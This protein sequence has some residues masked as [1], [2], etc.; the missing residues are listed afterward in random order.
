MARAR[1]LTSEALISRVGLYDHPNCITRRDAFFKKIRNVLELQFANGKSYK[2]GGIV[3]YDHKND[4]LQFEVRDSY[5]AELKDAIN[6]YAKGDN[7]KAAQLQ[8]FAVQKIESAQ[9]VRT[10][11]GS[12]NL[13]HLKRVISV[14]LLEDLQGEERRVAVDM[15]C[16]ALADSFLSFGG[17]WGASEAGVWVKEEGDDFIATFQINHNDLPPSLIDLE[18]SKHEGVFPSVLISAKED[19][20]T[21]GISIYL[22]QDGESVLVYQGAIT[23]E[24]RPEL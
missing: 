2:L 23:L 15:L 16:E 4:K 11:E 17:Q 1:F 20:L 7:S 9:T 19:Y 5:S 10:L 24:D 6:M 12:K 8:E 18:N 14:S 3:A 22:V 13:Q 21:S